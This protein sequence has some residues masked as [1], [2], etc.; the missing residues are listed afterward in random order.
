MS[1]TVGKLKE[2]LSK[3]DDDDGVLVSLGFNGGVKTIVGIREG[4]IH[5]NAMS[6]EN[7]S[8]KVITYPSSGSGTPVA[9]ILA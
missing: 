8:D 7:Q 3:Y 1:M 9:L 2:M 4:R 5:E 6:I